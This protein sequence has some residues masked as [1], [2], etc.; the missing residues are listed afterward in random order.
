MTGT[1][2]HRTRLER[3]WLGSGRTLLWCCLN[4]S[5]AGEFSGD[6]PS[7]RKMIGFTKHWG[8]SR[9]LLG[10]LYAYRATMPSDLISL[11]RLNLEA[12]AIGAGND[13]ALVV[14]AAEADSIVLAFGSLHPFCLTRAGYVVETLFARRTLLCIRTTREGHPAHPVREPYTDAPIGYLRRIAA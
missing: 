2:N 4:P 7:V 14:M 12:E 6:D 1:Q 10:N 3:C 9:M 13:E 11:L 5:T 8:Y